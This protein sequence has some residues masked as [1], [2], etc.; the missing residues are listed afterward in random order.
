LIP[1]Q[2]FLFIGRSFDDKNTNSTQLN[3][4]INMGKPKAQ[5]QEEVTLSK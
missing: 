2:L 3:P 1:Q 4:T 5:K